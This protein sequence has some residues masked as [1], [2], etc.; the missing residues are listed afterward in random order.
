MSQ[1]N[2]QLIPKIA[3]LNAFIDYL[4]Y[5]IIQNSLWK[6]NSAG[7]GNIPYDMFRNETEDQVGGLIGSNSLT[8]GC[9]LKL[10]DKIKTHLKHIIILQLGK[11]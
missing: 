5:E 11:I 3:Q 6:E 9:M 10:T 1:K 7:I 2:T 8:F 4:S